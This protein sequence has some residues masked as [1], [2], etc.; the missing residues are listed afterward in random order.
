MKFILVIRFTNS[1]SSS[2]QVED[3]SIPLS[4]NF[5]KGDINKLVNVVWLKTTI[6]SKVRQCSQ[7]RLRL[8][9]NGR[10]L[11]ENT[12]FKKEVFQPRLNRHDE[13]E[14]VEEDKKIYI[15]CVIGEK[16]TRAQLNQENQLDNRPQEVST[17][18]EV[19][20]F[21]RLLQQGFSQED[22]NQLRRQF[23]SIYGTE[24]INNRGRGSSEIRDLE[25][26][27]ARQRALRQLEERWIESTANNS[28]GNATVETTQQEN[29]TGDQFQQVQ[30]PQPSLDL[31]EANMNED[32]LIGSKMKSFFL[33][34]MKEESFATPQS[35]PKIQ[36]SMGLPSNNDPG[37]E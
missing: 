30:V 5:D 14:N 26:E 22:V 29:Q 12:D 7:N 13:D 19:I 17:A 9:Y 10:V 6:R 20:G 37:T 36:W 2:E 16:L 28:A 18:P 3:L 27:E 15:H 33:Q 8:I 1:L 23:Y 35:V 32:I 11:N 21:D 31:N 4:I 34:Q 24:L 25:E